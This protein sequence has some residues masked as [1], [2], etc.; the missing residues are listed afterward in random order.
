MTRFIASPEILYSPDFMPFALMAANT[1]APGELLPDGRICITPRNISPV[2][3][4][5]ITIF[6]QAG[7]DVENAPVF[8]KMTPAKYN[9]A[10]PVGISNRSYTEAGSDTPIIRKWAEW[11]DSQHEH[12]TAE[13]GDKMVPGNS[14]GAEL[15]SAELK[16]LIGL[17]G[18]TLYM[19]H[20]VNALLPEP[21]PI[22]V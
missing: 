5:D 7:G 6:L 11:K 18:Y 13:D 9:T 12:L 2:I 20:E 8:I 10:V 14:W 17:S 16:V 19:T 3:G 15:T 21:E 4:E 22:E 1:Q